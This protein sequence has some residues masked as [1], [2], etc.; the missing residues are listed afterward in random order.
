MNHWTPLKPHVCSLRWRPIK[1]TQHQYTINARGISKLP[2]Y[3]C[4]QQQIILPRAGLRSIQ[5][6]TTNSIS[7]FSILP[8]PLHP[9]LS[10]LPQQHLPVN[11]AARLSV[12]F[13]NAG[14]KVLKRSFAMQSNPLHN[15]DLHYY[16][17]WA[18]KAFFLFIQ[19][20]SIY[21]S[22]YLGG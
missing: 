7:T 6:S 20:V 15:R 2:T 17:F 13:M 4:I 19:C 8:C 9:R 18:R 3:P 12:A 11:F 22:V 14:E 5:F 21:L 10:P 1:P 16:Y